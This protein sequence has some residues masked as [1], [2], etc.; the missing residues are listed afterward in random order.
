MHVANRL[1][2]LPLLFPVLSRNRYLIQD[3]FYCIYR[4]PGSVHSAVHYQAVCHYRN[5]KCFHILR[6]NVIP[7]GSDEMGWIDE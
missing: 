6:N 2:I 3:F 7:A 4:V 1:A 5:G